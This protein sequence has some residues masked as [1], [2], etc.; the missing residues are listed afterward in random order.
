[1]KN[2]VIPQTKI[3]KTFNIIFEKDEFLIGLA[4]CKNKNHLI[5]TK[6]FTSKNR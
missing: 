4:L 2:Y 3:S 6:I 1:M 5:I